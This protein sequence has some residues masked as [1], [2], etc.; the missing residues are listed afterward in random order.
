MIQLAPLCYTNSVCLFVCLFVLLWPKLH[1][2]ELVDILQ[3][4]WT[5]ELL[6]VFI[7]VTPVIISYPYSQHSVARNPSTLYSWFLVTN[8]Q[9]SRDTV[10]HSIV[11]FRQFSFFC[12]KDSIFLPWPIQ[13]MR[14]SRPKQS[15]V[16]G[17]ISVPIGGDL[18]MSDWKQN[19]LQDI[20][21]RFLIVLPGILRLFTRD[22]LS[23]MR[24][25]Q[26]T[27]CVIQL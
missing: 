1:R 25:D 6:F 2:T 4:A 18:L 17:S 15:N 10:R 8:A 23:P 24:K 22:F 7:R 21:V 19:A 16:P 5:R 12:C 13:L 14:R 27:V 3:F 9:R 11:G 20:N 26:E